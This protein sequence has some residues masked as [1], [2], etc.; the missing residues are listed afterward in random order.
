MTKIYDPMNDTPNNIATRASLETLMSEKQ[1]DERTVSMQARIIKQ[2]QMEK[3]AT[4]KLIAEEEETNAE[5]IEVAVVASIHLNDQP[6]AMK[7]D[8]L[9][10]P[11]QGFLEYLKQQSGAIRTE[12]ESVGYICGM[13]MNDRTL[14][15]GKKQEKQ[16]LVTVPNMDK[17]AMLKHMRNLIGTKSQVKSE[18]GTTEEH[19]MSA[20][21]GHQERQ[22]KETR[23]TK[24]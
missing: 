9:L 5:I 20:N 14:R 22:Q 23:C 7:W 19:S 4:L 8:K 21:M 6:Q 24:E 2:E 17:S 15:L 18:L 11:S 16:P 12:S 13:S 1:L 3:V 10:S